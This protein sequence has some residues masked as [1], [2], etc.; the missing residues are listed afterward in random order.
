MARLTLRTLLAYIDDTLDPATASELGKKVA[1]SE[2]AQALIERIKKVTRRRGITTPPVADETADPNVVAAYLDNVLASGAVKEVER[3]ALESDPHLAEIAACHQILTLILTEPVR[4]PPRAHQRMYGL[5][6]APGGDPSRQPNKALPVGG[7]APPAETDTDTEDA[8]AALLFGMKRYSASTPWAER[9]LLFGAAAVLALML[10]TG[11]LVSLSRE[12]VKPPDASAGSSYVALAPVPAPV[13]AP[14]DPKEREPDPPVPPMPKAKEPE[15]KPK[16]KEPEPKPKEKEKEKEKEPEPVPLPKPKDKPVAKF[17]PV[18]DPNNGMVVQKVDREIR[19]KV[20]VFALP[21]EGNRDALVSFRSDNWVCVPERARGDLDLYAGQPV[22]ALP[23]L[24][25]S[26]HVG[27]D[28][29]VEV[30]LWGNVPEQFP[31]RVF[32]SRVTFHVPPAG[33]AA[34]LTLHNGRA[35]LNPRA[36]APLKVR[37][38]AGDEVWDVVLSDAR[39]E[40]LVELISWYAPGTPFA[41]KDGENPRRDGRLAVVTGTAKL[42]DP[43]RFNSY[44]AV[45]ERNAV[46]WDS[47]KGTASAP[48]LVPADEPL[49]RTPRFDTAPPETVKALADLAAE[50]TPKEGA[51]NVLSALSKRLDKAA[52]RSDSAS[53]R[54]A[55]FAFAALATGELDGNRPLTELIDKLT[56]E[57]GQVH[58][59]TEH[60]LVTA[61]VGYVG[62]DIKHTATLHATVT[63]KLRSGEQKDREESANRLVSLLRGFVSPHNPDLESV[64]KLLLKDK[65]ALLEDKELAVQ[66]AARWNLLSLNQGAWV[67]RAAS[68]QAVTTAA[69]EWRARL[70]R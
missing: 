38:R 57:P 8:D 50:L 46:T 25:A 17:D 14:P 18:A 61:L 37:V 39:S 19:E 12:H 59:A 69:T 54:V 2:E 45:T 65:G 29:N 68:P 36:G 66:L 48:H 28:A 49:A 35:Y 27:K 47:V 31:I 22:M 7:A 43:K 55:V 20:G 10:A 42:S 33:F 16:E 26:A 52:V 3:A 70:K 4:V 40:L 44:D 58:W 63:M 24:K 53:A 9:L 64:E 30:H 11:V 32:E 56:T 23:G 60:A 67:P 1:A 5:V 6:P 62:R 41:V 15:P 21:A 51:P 34:D 13:V